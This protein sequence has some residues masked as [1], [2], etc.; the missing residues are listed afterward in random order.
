MILFDARLL[1]R[2]LRVAVKQMR[3]ARA[4]RSEF[5]GS[6]IRKLAAIICNDDREEIGEELFS[7]G[8]IQMIERI[9]NR[10]RIITVTQKSEHK[11]TARKHNSK[12][13]FPT[14]G[15]DHRVNFDEGKITDFIFKQEI[16]L[17]GAVNSAFFIDFQ[18]GRFSL[19]GFHPDDTR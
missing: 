13:G 3:T 15:T 19:T 18:R 6:G 2:G 1:E 17:P 12:E 7:Q 9:D 5:N 16:I 4:I 8:Y 14:A 10:L 11:M